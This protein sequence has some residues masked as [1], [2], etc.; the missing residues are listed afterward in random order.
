MSS[1]VW[2]L[3]AEFADRRRGQRHVR[4]RVV[5]FGHEHFQSPPYGRSGYAQFSQE[6]SQR[7]EAAR[8]AEIE[9]AHSV[10]VSA[11]TQQVLRWFTRVLPTFDVDDASCAECFFTHQ[12]HRQPT[13]RG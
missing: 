3:Q 2:A 5:R 7:I 8:L 13:A 4:N 12:R 6:R 10:L 1:L 9:R 11:E